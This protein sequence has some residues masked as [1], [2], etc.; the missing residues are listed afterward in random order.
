MRI[1]G[2]TQLLNH[3]SIDKNVCKWLQNA[4]IDKAISIILLSARG[5][6]KKYFKNLKIDGSSNID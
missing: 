1:E 3:R 2:T 6:N 4:F 5:R